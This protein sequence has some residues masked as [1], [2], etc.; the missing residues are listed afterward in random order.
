MNIL[1][2]ILT[3]LPVGKILDPLIKEIRVNVFCTMRFNGMRVTIGSQT[4]EDVAEL[5]LKSL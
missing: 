3:M 4:R 1:T 2:V 5:L